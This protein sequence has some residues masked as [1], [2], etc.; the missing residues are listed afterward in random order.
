MKNLFLAAVIACAPI[1]AF[2]QDVEQLPAAREN[3][4]V[5]QSRDVGWYT[6]HPADRQAML[7]QCERYYDSSHDPDCID[8]KQADGQ[9]KGTTMPHAVPSPD[10][11]HP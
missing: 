2:A 1:V 8:A 4:I 6:Q 11:V 10:S 7:E 9:A 3:A 5:T